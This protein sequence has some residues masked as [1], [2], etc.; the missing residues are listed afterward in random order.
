VTIVAVAT[1]S[2]VADEPHRNSKPGCGRLRRDAPRAR[3]GRRAAVSRDAAVASGNRGG[4][5]A[6]WG[7]R[8]SAE[9]RRASRSRGNARWLLRCRRCRPTQAASGAVVCLKS[10]SRLWVA[11]MSRHSDR[12]AD[13]P[14]RWNAV[15][16]HQRLGHDAAAVADL[17]ELRIEE[18]VRIAALQRPRP[19]R[20]HMLVKRLTYTA[21][22]GL[23]DAQA[24]ALDQLVDT[25]RRDA[26]DVGLLDHPSSG[27]S[28][29]RRGSRMLGT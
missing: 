28:E 25:S 12:A 11:V 6:K 4:C 2:D 7:E 21:D 5:C 19:E 16:D 29:R 15:G 10:F 18:H 24:K 23:A 27:C 17:L 26:A 8:A 1:A 3:T 22:L 20:F 14:R 9:A 13:L